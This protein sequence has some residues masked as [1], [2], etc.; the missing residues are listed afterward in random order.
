M[1][2]VQT[3]GLFLWHQLKESGVLFTGL[4][5]GSLDTGCAPSNGE[6]V[7]VL[8]F[9]SAGCTFHGPSRDWRRLRGHRSPVPV[10]IHG[11]P[12]QLWRAHAAI[13]PFA[14]GCQPCWQHVFI[15]L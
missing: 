8:A 1:G 14:K 6:G 7:P 5:V 15:V 2:P 12:A 11:A 13:Q 10:T 3:K 9:A 4:S